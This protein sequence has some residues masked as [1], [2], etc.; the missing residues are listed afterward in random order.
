MQPSRQPGL[1]FVIE[2]FFQIVH[3]NLFVTLGRAKPEPVPARHVNSLSREKCLLRVIL[4]LG[5]KGIIRHA[6][7]L[8]GEHGL[9]VFF[10]QIHGV[11]PQKRGVVHVMV[12]NQVADVF[13]EMGVIKNVIDFRENGF[14][15]IV[16]EHEGRVG[17]NKRAVVLSG[18]EIGG[19]SHCGC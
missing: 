8:G 18:D 19:T 4:H 5:E 1:V 9:E 10:H 6:R 7:I 13:I 12:H 16:H 14:A 11:V 2:E 3:A 15:F 17:R